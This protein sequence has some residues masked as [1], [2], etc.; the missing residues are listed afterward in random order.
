M[1]CQCKLCKKMDR[2]YKRWR[3]G[4]FNDKKEEKHGRNKKNK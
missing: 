3:K 4:L 1:D 2:E